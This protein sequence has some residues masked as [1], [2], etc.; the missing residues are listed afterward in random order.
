[1]AGSQRRRV[2]QGVRL[3]ASVLAALILAAYWPVLIG[4]IPIPAGLILQ[5]PPYETVRGP[6]FQMPQHAELGDLVTQWYPWRLQLSRSV[7]SL[8]LPA[9]N[10][11]NSLGAPFLAVPWNAVFSPLTFVYYVLPVPAAWALLFALRPTLAALFTWL[12]CRR[13]GATETGAAVG[14]VI[15]AFC[16]FMTGFQ[17]RPH[18]DTCIWLPL[19]CLCVH[20]MRHHP[21]AG[22]T[23]LVAVSFAL[24]ALSGHP[25]L[26]LHITI[27]GVAY[28]T[29]CVLSPP[30][31]VGGD[32]KRAGR[33]RFGTL[34]VVAGILAVGLAAVQIVPSLEWLH[35]INRPLVGAH[36]GAR[37]VAEIVSFV[38][39]D[40]QHNL[41]SAGVAIPEGASYVGML[42]LLTFPLAFLHRNRHEATFWVLML[43]A[44]LQVVYARGP[45][46]W[47]VD[48]TPVLGNIPNWRLLFVADF[49]LAVL[50]A[51]AIS[52]LDGWHG[53]TRNGT[54]GG[55]QSLPWWLTGTGV[56][57]VSGELVIL[58]HLTIAR[59]GLNRQSAAAM[60]GSIAFAILAF[61]VVVV[62]IRSGAHGGKTAV[63]AL[64]AV[65]VDLGS[66]AYG[67][68]P[69]FR[70]RQVFPE[71]PTFEFLRDNTGEGFRVASVDCTYGVNFEA[72]YGLFAP[73]GYD[74][75]LE[76]SS[77]VLVSVCNA[78]D[79]LAVETPKVLASGP[80]LLDMLSVKYLVATTCNDSVARLRSAPE[81]FKPV[82]SSGSVTVFQ[83]LSALPQATLV[84][85]RGVRV[86]TAQDALKAVLRLDFDPR[87]EVIVEE[88]VLD[89]PPIGVAPRLRSS[90]I[91]LLEAR[92]SRRAY[93][94][95]APERSLLVLSESWY[96]GWRVSVDGVEARLLHANY[97]LMGVAVESGLHTVVFSFAPGNLLAAA[98]V[99]GVCLLTAALL[100][101]SSALSAGRV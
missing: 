31:E 1:M 29:W 86:M 97:A 78:S 10:P 13:I 3:L 24:T 87:H 93:R 85:G 80:G 49:S 62:F 45:V 57:L 84:S 40:F 35:Q 72:A 70:P 92:D 17:G 11:H 79:N 28:A 100:F 36:W 7:R 71:T 96:P 52:G 90:V 65:A 75:R 46:A 83:N 51:L 14:A 20:R 81:R 64:V 67:S 91:K 22:N 38:S 23:A 74:C 30:F 98:F 82:F 26:A 73:S 56:T 33:W 42:A 15:F 43:A 68:I 77:R 99:S 50:A 94:I 4:K 66:A 44:V 8:E 69:F 95:N 53:R 34:F 58:W 16:G 101:F 88:A 59:N 6:G 18:V 61:A 76:R 12:L 5:F 89:Q 47:L 41:N 39:R 9:W 48:R 27:V 54:S 32:T 2:T 25:E 60:G 21:S 55:A 19:V 63:V 37:P